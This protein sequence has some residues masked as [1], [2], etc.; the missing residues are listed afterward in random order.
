[1]HD[2]VWLAVFDDPEEPDDWEIIGVFASPDGGKDACHAAMTAVEQ[3]HVCGN[4]RPC[5]QWTSN[6]DGT[7]WWDD[8]TPQ[9]TVRGLVVQP[10]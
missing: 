8:D 2:E 10:G 9:Y 1:M 3:D 6:A 5:M 4:S 7:W